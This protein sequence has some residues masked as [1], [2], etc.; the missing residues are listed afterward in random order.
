MRLKPLLNMIVFMGLL[1]ACSVGPTGGQILTEPATKIRLPMGYIPNVQFAPFYVGVEKGLFQQAAIEIDFDY[2]FETDGVTLVGNNNLQFAL[3]SGEQVLLARAQGL[4]IVYIAAWYRDYP[5]SIVA[6]KSSGIDEPSDLIGKRVGIPG[7]FGASYVGY[8]AILESAGIDQDRVQ[9]ETIGFNQ[10]EALVTGQV[11]AAVVYSNNEPLQLE[12][13]GYEIN[14]IDVSDFVTLASNGL[15]TNESTIENDPE[16]VRR[17]VD[18]FLE[19]V[20]YTIEHPVDA[21]EISK[22]YVENL[23]NADQEIQRNVLNASIELWRSERIGYSDI[24]AWENMQSVL[25]NMGMLS[26]PVDLEVSFTN[27]FIQ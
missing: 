5:V 20:Q 9:L 17:M 16:L 4:P 10:V 21:Y 13:L 11:D 1:T 18:A 22:K 14:S 15:I 2:S 27:R 24:L 3:V 23:E 25:L 19:G 26:A 8:S 6:E 12:G 7:L